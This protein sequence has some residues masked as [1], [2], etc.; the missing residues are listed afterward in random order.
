MISMSQNS[1]SKSSLEAMLDSLREEE[2]NEKPKDIPPA[3][4]A[5]PKPTPLA[6][7]PSLKRPL[8]SISEK[9]ENGGN[10]SKTVISEAED[11]ARGF[12]KDQPFGAKR[13]K[14][15]ETSESPYLEEEGT[16]WDDCIDYFIEQK[17][18]V[19]C[20]VRDTHWQLGEIQSTEGR[21]TS[22]L[23]D[24]GNVVSVQVGGLLPAN[25]EILVGVDDLIQ[26]SYLNEPSV[27]HN[28]QHRFSR[29]S[30]YTKAGPVLVAMNPFKDVQLYGD[31]YVT[32]YRQKL[33]DSPHVYATAD[34][35]YTEM[36]RDEFNQSIIISGESGSGKTE[37]AKI[38]IEYL[39]A[40]GGGRSGVGHKVLKMSCILEAFGNAKTSTNNNS[41]RFGKLIKI[42]FTETGI[43]CGSEIQTFLF[44]KSRVVQLDKGERS[45]HVFY[46][47]CAGAPSDLKERLKL[48]KASDFKYLNQSDC[49]VIRNVDDTS[50][51]H[52]LMEALDI[53]RI[54]KEDQENIFKM[55]A[56]VLWLGNISFQVVDGEKHAEVLHDEAVANVCSLIGCSALELILLLSSGKVQAGKDEVA[57]RLTLQQAMDARDALAMFIYSSWC[58]WLINELNKALA[59]DKHCAGRS[60]CILDMYGFQ[61]L[62]KNSHDQFCINYA[63][64]RLRQHFNGHLLKLEQEVLCDTSGF[65]EKNRDQLHSDTAQMLSSCS[66]HQV[67][68]SSIINLSQ[69]S[70]VR[71]M[72]SGAMDL[73]QSLTTN[74]KDQFVELMQHL[75]NT[76]PHFILCIK[77][78]NKQLPGTFE[79]DLV[80]KQ[81][82]CSQVLEVVRIARSGYASQMT[83]QEF[84]NRYGFLLLENK[85]SRDPLSTSIAILQQFDIRPE[86]YQVGYK[87]IFLRA[88][89]VSILEDIRK[90]VQLGT[91]ELQKCFHGHRAPCNFHELRRSVI[92][93]Q[94]YVRGEIARGKFNI[95]GHSKFEKQLTAVVQ[96]QSATRG[97]LARKN[98]VQFR[99]SKIMMHEGQKHGR[100]LAEILGLAQECLP[101]SAEDLQKRVLM[102]E[103]ELGKKDKENAA[104]REQV[105]QFEDRWLESEAKMKAKEE[106]WQK[107]MSSMRMTVAGARRS[108]REDQA[109]V[110]SGNHEG[111]PSPQCYDSE[112]SISEGTRTTGAS[113]PIKPA[114]NGVDSRAGAE[115]NGSLT[116]VS[117]LEKELETTNVNFENDAKSIMETK[118]E[119]NAGEE[120]R[121][122]KQ[123]FEA[124]KKDYNV[125][126]KELKGKLQRLGR[127]EGESGRLKWWGKRSRKL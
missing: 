84:T 17:L 4:P 67:F 20:Q 116:S 12:R 125:R 6:R 74:F 40:V 126:L 77:P 62:K 113:T 25:P 106:M 105:Q 124:W 127:S 111:F 45:Y 95:L 55:V 91:L 26:L 101:L 63:N 53:F 14:D 58:D 34:S 33:L 93:L 7:L 9:R 54:S 19:W 46:Q 112:D 56:A 2:G 39:A 69:K 52:L 27:M 115:I 118:S 48:K 79:E 1:V 107:Q 44:E 3:L 32:A 21:R 38:A 35:A 68:A 104:L 90:R 72:K 109:E 92:T 87:K 120:L 49:L 31:E 100:T 103:A 89:Q 73:K 10:D 16:E 24:D 47:L 114:T 43:M 110:Q 11:E 36:I 76:T 37:T 28:L 88:G 71:C 82:R 57:K 99:D 13:P 59:M 123:K 61:S 122:L 42:H 22:V 98:F 75:E 81:F 70:L 50:N 119:K 5:R 117:C 94:S 96:I 78:N 83:H 65:L 80:L 86:M 8:P 23:L 30:I 41:S 29:E 102:A 121:N 97:W 64:E 85:S 15:M 108:L 60:V 18:R 66:W 51:F